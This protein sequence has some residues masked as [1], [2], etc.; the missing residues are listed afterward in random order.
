M[1]QHG[2]QG[3]TLVEVLIVVAIIGVLASAVIIGIGTR[4][5]ERKLQADAERLMLAIEQ[6]RRTATARNQIWG[7][8][9]DGVSYE[10]LWLD[11]TAGEWLSPEEQPFQT[12][13]LRETVQLSILSESLVLDTPRS[14]SNTPHIIILPNGEVSPFFISLSDEFSTAVWNIAS[15]GISRTNASKHDPS[16]VLQ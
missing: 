6:A 14:E 9:H 2:H 1:S 4:D 12:K 10:F 11:E 16:E 3:Y 5:T 7:L 15:D 8:R 13:L